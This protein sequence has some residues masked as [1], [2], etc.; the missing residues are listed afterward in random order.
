MRL[1]IL[2]AGGYGKTVADI[3]WQ[4]GAY[5]Q[6]QFLDDNSPKAVGK[7]ADFVRLV[8]DETVFYPAFG[9]N[10]GRVNW[11]KRLTD[12]GCKIPILI[13]ST[14]YVSPTAVLHPGTVVL[15]MAVVSTDCIIHEGCIINCGAMVDHGCMLEAGVHVCLNA[16]V[17]AENRIPRCTKIEAGQ[18]VENRTYL[19]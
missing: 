9:N 3:A 2:G 11:L 8:D 16:V 15:P 18:I 19:L 4:S 14:A 13:H 12:A 6:I 17:K 1:V 7:C 5:A 10:D